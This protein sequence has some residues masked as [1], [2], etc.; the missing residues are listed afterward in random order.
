MKNQ[1]EK[2]L[3]N[4][5]PEGQQEKTDFKVFQ[6]FAADEK[7]LN[8]SSIAHFTASVFVLNESHDKILGIYHKIYQS[9]GWVGGHAD[10]NSD[11]LAVA[12]KEVQE[13]TGLRSFKK[14]SEMP[15]SIEALPVFGH[16][17]RKYGYVSAHIHLNVTFLF[18]AK[19]S[20]SLQ[21]NTDETGGLAWIPLEK[22]S[23]KSSEKEMRVIY[24]KIITRIINK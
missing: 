18:E 14:L 22:F 15:I 1:I 13:E 3:E 4:F 10:G 8:R 9:W 16:H 20:D 6:D 17:H 23:E 24:D 7:N 12:V 11:L 19:E 21:K 5:V 2:L